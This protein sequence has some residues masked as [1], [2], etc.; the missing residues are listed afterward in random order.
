MVHLLWFLWL[1]EH[2]LCDKDLLVEGG[3][4]GAQPL[5]RSVITL[6]AVDLNQH[7]V[8]VD[9]AGNNELVY[10]YC[11]ARHKL[12]PHVAEDHHWGVKD[13]CPFV[14]CLHLVLRVA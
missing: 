2:F 14:E 1:T 12:L 13:K 10:D 5:L 3:W 6:V 7:A 4:Y 11:L 8:K 9:H